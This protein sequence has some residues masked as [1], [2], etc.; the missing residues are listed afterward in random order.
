M[1]IGYARVSTSSQTYDRQ[2][3]E[4]TAAGVDRSC[5][6]ADKK[7]GKDFDRSGL[8]AALA[9]ARQGDTLV[10]TSLDR[11]GRSLPGVFSV[12]GELDERG[13]NL[14]SLKESIDLSTSVGRML[15][16]IFASLAQY[17]VDLMHERAADA[18]AAREARGGNS[19]RPRKLTDAQV[20][21]IRFLKD[22]EQ[23]S[24]REIAADMGV[25]R[26]TV[27]RALDLGETSPATTRNQ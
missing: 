6:Y 16:G 20:R 17:E 3:D 26:A 27:Y 23:R 18:R 15:A 19:G 11:L 22:Q 21:H 24:A 14:K 8:D 12:I 2:V 1:E 9:Y 13:I 4:L 5:V 7:T 10:V 25:S